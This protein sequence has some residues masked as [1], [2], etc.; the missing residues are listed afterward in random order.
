MS[1]EYHGCH[2]S[3]RLVL[4]FLHFCLW[5]VYSPISVLVAL[6]RK[7]QHQGHEGPYHLLFLSLESCIRSFRVGRAGEGEERPLPHEPVLRI[8]WQPFWFPTVEEDSPP[9]HR[10]SS[11]ARMF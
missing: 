10:T 9:R 3:C 5:C 1:Y 8:P 7:G 6:T 11:R 2:D 4:L